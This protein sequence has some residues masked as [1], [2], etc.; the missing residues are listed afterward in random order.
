ME[1]ITSEKDVLPS[2]FLGQIETYQGLMDEF[3]HF[4]SFVS[5]P[6]SLH[7]A[8]KGKTES[9]PADPVEIRD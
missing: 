1:G 2:L 5:N 7:V 4:D 8:R 6:A 3:G 9:A